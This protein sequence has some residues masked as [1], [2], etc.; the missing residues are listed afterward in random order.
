MLTAM[1]ELFD[2]D[3]ALTMPE[4][5]EKSTTDGV[6]VVNQMPTVVMGS[7][8]DCTVCLERLGSGKKLHCGHVFHE[9]CISQ[10]LSAHNSCPVCRRKLESYPATE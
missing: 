4:G 1:D 6:S 9:I 3:L 7:G 2:L 8:R 5:P 10:W